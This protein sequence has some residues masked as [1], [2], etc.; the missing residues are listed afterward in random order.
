MKK[1][2]WS[3]IALLTIFSVL[4]TAC[5]TPQTAQLSAEEILVKS[6]EK[7][8]AMKTAQIKMVM[9]MTA[10]GMKFSLNAEGV[11]ESP[12]KAHLKM[13]LMGQTIEVLTLSSTETYMKTGTA[14]EKIPADQMQSS[15]GMNTNL[16]IQQSELL[17]YLKNLSYKNIEKIG[18]VDCYHLTFDMDMQKAL[19][20]AM[21][22]SGASSLGEIKSTT[23]TGEMWVGVDDF[24]TRKLT[25]TMN[26]EV[27]AQKMDLTMTLEMS[28]FD[29]PVTFP[30]PN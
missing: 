30:N 6:Q 11:V 15:S 20:L 27:Q 1:T 16:A 18:G 5:N 8:A 10:S 14:W 23:T 17:K 12:D 2:L 9:D 24:Y 26:L 3:L 4:L 29:K 25:F 28:E 19:E 22:E 7:S 21:G 13:S